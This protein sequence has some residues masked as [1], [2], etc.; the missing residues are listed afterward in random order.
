MGLGVWA[1][2]VLGVV[3]GCGGWFWGK[4]GWGGGRTGRPEWVC[5]FLRAA[6]F[7]R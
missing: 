7:V 3:G 5:R 4:G 6:R 1:C 2:L